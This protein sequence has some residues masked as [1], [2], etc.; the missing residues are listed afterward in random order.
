MISSTTVD[1][2]CGAD[3]ILARARISFYR[4]LCCRSKPGREGESREQVSGGSIR[5]VG[6]AAPYKAVGSAAKGTG[7]GR[8][9]KLRE[10]LI[11]MQKNAA[12]Q[13]VEISLL[14]SFFYL[15]FFTSLFCSGTDM[16][17]KI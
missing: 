10:A 16:Y 8:F 6:D 14:L 15:S 17:Y 3:F 7:N 2:I 11:R 1:F 5:A 13:R 12:V 9:V 4:R